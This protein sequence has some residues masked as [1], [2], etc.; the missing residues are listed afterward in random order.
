MKMDVQIR[1]ESG[2]GGFVGYMLIGALICYFM[3][4]DH[5]SLASLGTWLF[6]IFWPLVL[7]W[8]F[9]WIVIVIAAIA[10]LWVIFVDLFL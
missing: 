9:F 7:V 1:K 6:I 8:Y 5:A 3:N 4:G 10:I 2:F